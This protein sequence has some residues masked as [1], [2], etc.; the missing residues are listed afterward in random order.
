MVATVDTL[1]YLVRGGRVSLAAGLLGDLLQVKPILAIQDD[2]TAACIA[3][4]RTRRAALEYML[5]YVAGR[6]DGHRA[7]QL[8]VMQADAPQ[9]AQEFQ[10]VVAQSWPTA[11]VV[12]TDFTPVMGGH[13]GPGLIGLAYCYE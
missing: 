4:R 8:A 9:E 13:T 2:G 11:T 10:R 6:T 12:V 7:L 5:R 1:E 3:R